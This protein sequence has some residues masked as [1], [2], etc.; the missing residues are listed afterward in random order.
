MNIP[1]TQPT[2]T[3]TD[4]NAALD[5]SENLDPKVT[6][7]V[8]NR[9]SDG[10]ILTVNGSL[11]TFLKNQWTGLGCVPT[12]KTL[13]DGSGYTFCDWYETLE[14]YGNPPTEDLSISRVAWRENVFC[15]LLATSENSTFCKVNL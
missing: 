9:I 8:L 15:S 14:K 6:N 4:T 2:I 5:S 11:L 12:T 10:T 1:I 7:S 13:T 3:I